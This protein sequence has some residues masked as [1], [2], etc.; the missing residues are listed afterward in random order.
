MQNVWEAESSQA[1]S[2]MSEKTS[3]ILRGSATFILWQDTSLDLLPHYASH[4]KVAAVRQLLEF[5][6]NPGTKVR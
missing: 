5:G 6:C 4:G 1:T 3:R 2:A